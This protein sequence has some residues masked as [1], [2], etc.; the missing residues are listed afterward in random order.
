MRDAERASQV[1]RSGAS[2]QAGPSAPGDGTGESP[3]P[4][5]EPRFLPQRTAHSYFCKP[6]MG[7]CE[8]IPQFSSRPLSIYGYLL[9]FCAGQ[10]AGSKNKN[11]TELSG[12]STTTSGMLVHS[13]MSF[14]HG[15]GDNFTAFGVEAHK[16]R[17]KAQ[18]KTAGLRIAHQTKNNVVALANAHGA[19]SVN[20]WNFPSL[21]RF[22]LLATTV[23]HK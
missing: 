1:M 15:A 22:R 18:R 2:I 12:L 23:F 4:P 13:P 17:T 19:T 5:N 20:L 7:L 14:G 11:A 6:H 9:R 16:T 8:T 21:L 3:G 10:G